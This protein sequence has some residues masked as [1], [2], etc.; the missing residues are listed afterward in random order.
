M[1]KDIH[2]K[3]NH[4]VLVTCSCGNTFETGSTVESIRIE[5][6]SKCHPFWTGEKRYVDIE[7]RVD[8]FKKKQ[9]I[10]EKARKKR[11][12]RV[13]A[14]IARE[15]ARKEAPKSLKDMLKSMQ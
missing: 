1:K 7:G 11:I 6:C 15:K 13:K 9:D 14:R 3:Y 2:P 8:K 5:I 4:K 12:K 10:G